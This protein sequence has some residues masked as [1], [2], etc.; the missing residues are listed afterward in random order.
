MAAKTGTDKVDML[1]SSFED[2]MN[3]CF[4]YKTR[5]KKSSESVWMPTASVT[6]L[7]DAERSIKK[8]K[9]VLDGPLS[10]KN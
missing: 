4:E 8:K 5:K 9:E 6:S 1:H 2:A 10:R 3:Q 7:H